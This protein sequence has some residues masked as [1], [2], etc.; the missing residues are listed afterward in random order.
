MKTFTLKLLLGSNSVSS[1][2]S[3]EQYQLLYQAKESGEVDASVITTVNL[4]SENDSHA[5]CTV[6]DLCGGE[7]FKILQINIEYA[8]FP[9]NA[10]PEMLA[11]LICTTEEMVFVDAEGR[12]IVYDGIFMNE[13]NLADIDYQPNYFS[14]RDKAIVN[15]QIEV[16]KRSDVTFTFKQ[17]EHYVGSD[18]S[19]DTIFDWYCDTRHG[20]GV[21]QEDI[22]DLCDDL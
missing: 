5:S 13:V 8:H 16:N 12:K 2:N 14:D 17:V 22:I 15:L 3:A 21:T 20:D 9:V 4:L 6:K 1:V 7:D 10:T 11:R 19:I 18:T